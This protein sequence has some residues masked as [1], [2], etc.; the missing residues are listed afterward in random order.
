MARDA[1]MTR[2]SDHEAETAIA[3]SAQTEL[4]EKAQV[5]EELPD[6]GESNAVVGGAG[7]GAPTKV[8]TALP[9]DRT[10]DPVR[11]YL[12]EIRP[13]NLLPERAKSRS[14]NELKLAAGR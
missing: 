4:A 13:V 3:G 9:S 2:L 8:A 14:P 12:R 5:G 10:D 1:K 6:E 7:W 11:M